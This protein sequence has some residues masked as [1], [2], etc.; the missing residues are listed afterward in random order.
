MASWGHRIVKTRN[1]RHKCSGR[2]ENRAGFAAR[3]D[4]VTGRAGRVSTAQRDLCLSHAAKFCKKHGIDLDSLPEVD[5]ED[6]GSM[7]DAMGKVLR[8]LVT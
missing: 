3:Y 2:C 8:G 5:R 4:Y 1:N 6:Y 7:A